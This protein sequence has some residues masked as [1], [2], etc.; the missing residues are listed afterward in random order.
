MK[1]APDNKAPHVESAGLHL[2]I[3]IT[4]DVIFLHYRSYIKPEKFL[5]SDKKTVDEKR[6]GRK[7]G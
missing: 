3:K 5:P 6:K 7:P 2:L 1:S 4:G